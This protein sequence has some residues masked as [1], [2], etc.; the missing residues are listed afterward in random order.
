MNLE[1][2]HAMPNVDWSGVERVATGK[3]F[4]GEINSYSQSGRLINESEFGGC[5]KI[6]SKYTMPTV[7]EKELNH[8]VPVKW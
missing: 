1:S 2:L 7:E 4:P 3:V 5:Q 6:S 8:L